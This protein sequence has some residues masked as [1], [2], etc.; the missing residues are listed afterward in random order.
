MCANGWFCVYTALHLTSPQHP[1]D[2]NIDE[3]TAGDDAD[4]D[5]DDDDDD[6]EEEVCASVIVSVSVCVCVCVLWYRVCCD[7]KQV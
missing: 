4:D 2:L 3:S 1:S 7:G 5:D 6:D